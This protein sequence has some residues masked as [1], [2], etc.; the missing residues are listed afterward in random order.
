MYKDCTIFERKYQGNSVN[1]RSLQNIRTGKKLKLI[2][3]R[4]VHLLNQVQKIQQT[5]VLEKT[6][7]ANY[8]LS[9]YI[10]F[11]LRSRDERKFIKLVYKDHDSLPFCDYH[12]R[13]CWRL[14]KTT[15]NAF[16]YKHVCLFRLL[17]FGYLIIV[18]I[19]YHAGIYASI[20]HYP[21]ES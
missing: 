21:N 8:K 13:S 7:R 2:R 6:S 9:K 16:R 11:F 15:S 20:A 19:Y 4:E 17:S 14:L 18:E 1:I 10:R 12:R 5:E 3:Q